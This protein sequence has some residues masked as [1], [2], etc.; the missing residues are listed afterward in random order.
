MKLVALSIMK[1]SKLFLYLFETDDLVYREV[2]EV[3]GV[4]GVVGVVGVQGVGG[5]GQ[6][7]LM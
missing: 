3:G 1:R 2:G 6:I 4:G 7:K 5:V